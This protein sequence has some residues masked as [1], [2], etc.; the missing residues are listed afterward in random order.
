MGVWQVQGHNRPL[1]LSPL[2]LPPLLPPQGRPT[3]APLDMRARDLAYTNSLATM[4]HHPSLPSPPYPLWMPRAF[5][6]KMSSEPTVLD[7]GANPGKALSPQFLELPQPCGKI[8]ANHRF[9][10][11]VLGLSRAKPHKQNWKPRANFSFLLNGDPT[12]L[13][14]KIDP[15]QHSKFIWPSVHH[16]MRHFSLFVFVQRSKLAV[17]PPLVDL[18]VGGSTSLRPI[19]ARALPTRPSR[20]APSFLLFSRPKVPRPAS[21]EGIETK[22]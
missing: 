7:T 10:H 6:L 11:R 18:D 5:S 16:Q 19:P 3:S 20:H 1:Q 22:Q 4:C 15:N 17:P 13:L 2:E 14:T 21:T 9:R 8:V 12:S